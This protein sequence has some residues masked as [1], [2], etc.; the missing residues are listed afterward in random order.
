[1]QE[2]YLAIKALMMAR[3]YLYELFH[4]ALGGKPTQRLM[5]AISSNECADSVDEYL[6]PGNGLEEF[7]AFAASVNASDPDFLECVIDEYDQLFVG[8]GA[9]K[10]ALWESSYIS[11]DGILFGESV[12]AVRTWY[13]SDGVRAR[14]QGNVPEDHLSLMMAFLAQ[15][16]RIA[17]NALDAKRF[18]DVASRLEQDGRFLASHINNWTGELLERLGEEEGLFY[19]RVA[20]GA[21][22]FAR[23]DGVFAEQARQ[24]A[25]QVSDAPL[26]GADDDGFTRMEIAI[27]QLRELRLPF[28]EENELSCVD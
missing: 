27:S 12:L 10:L 25:K 26:W 23:A 18:P 1:M 17:Y 28:L 7:A 5:A 13:R 6:R 22:A 2:D 11:D 19:S 16:A 8:L 9:P 21:V 14:R 20:H 3:S 24:W 4:K 15:S